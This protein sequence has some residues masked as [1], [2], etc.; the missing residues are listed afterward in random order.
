M[1]RKTETLNLRVAPDLKDLI[2]QAAE[3]ERR[4]I[5]SFV[6]VLVRDYCQEKSISTG[7]KQSRLPEE[8]IQGR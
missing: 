7:Q 4:S 1:V 2:R 8:G 3:A 5:S 6:E